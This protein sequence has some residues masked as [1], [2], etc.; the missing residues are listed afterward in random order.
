[1]VSGMENP[2]A[3]TMGDRPAL[4]RDV[5]VRSDGDVSAPGCSCRSL[6]G[7]CQ[8]ST[9]SPITSARATASTCPLSPYLRRSS[10]PW[11]FALTLLPFL[12]FADKTNVVRD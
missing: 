5:Q 11:S 6:A 4:F 10:L 3:D 7:R 12:T 8:R 2:V 1:M 9:R